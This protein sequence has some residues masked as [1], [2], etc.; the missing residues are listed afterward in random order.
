MKINYVSFLDPFYHKGGGEMVLSQLLK[1][2]KQRG[3]ELRLNTCSPNN[4]DSFID[5]DLTLIADIFN[6]PGEKTKFSH[7]KIE[8]IINS[9]PYVH[10]DN[11]YVDVCDLDYLPCNGDNQNIKAHVP[12]AE[13]LNYAADLRSMTSGRGVFTIEFDYYDDVPDH[14]MQKIVDEA[15][16]RREAENS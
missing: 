1:I 13:V 10:F 15:K 8:T 3:H 4:N 7:N 6:C 14:L 9:G 2:G 11:A 12:M 5:Q 16:A